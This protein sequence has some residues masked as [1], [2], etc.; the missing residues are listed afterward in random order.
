M[1]LFTTESQVAPILVQLCVILITPAVLAITAIS[2][3]L[4]QVLVF[5][6]KYR[7]PN[8]VTS[9][10]SDDV[11]YLDFNTLHKPYSAIPVVYRLRS[12]P[13]KED[14]I[15]DLSSIYTKVRSD[16]SGQLMHW[17]LSVYPIQRLGFWFWTKDESFDF[18]NHVK[19]L[20]SRVIDSEDEICS[21]V[22]KVM[23]KGFQPKRPLWDITVVP[24]TITSQQAKESTP[25][26]ILIFRLSHSII[27]GLSFMKLY[28]R[29]AGYE[30]LPPDFPLVTS[31][32]KLSIGQLAL[33]W[34]HGLFTGMY[35][36]ACL[37]QKL[38]DCNSVLNLEVYKPSGDWILTSF[39]T[40]PLKAIKRAKI[41]FNCSFNDIILCG[42]FG[43][44]QN[45]MKKYGG[46]ICP[47]SFHCIVAAPKPDHPNDTIANHL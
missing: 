35:V 39:P 41:A 36:Y 22:S 44:L 28:Y 29:L 18:E 4:K 34:A 2:F 19:F 42:I 38:P 14:I 47:P 27:D 17:K 8:I 24:Y 11:L 3:V 30:R 43:G 25:K 7:D 37:M 45:Y 32:D 16:G 1:N 20:E 10:G 26:S 21:I 31:K 23:R 15:R 33:E 12:C 5:I 40:I 6:T 13:T 9:I 46:G